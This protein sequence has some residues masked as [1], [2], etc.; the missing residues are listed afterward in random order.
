MASTSS[1]PPSQNSGLM[2][3][4]SA[5][6][7][8][9]AF[10]V[11]ALGI[12]IALLMEDVPV[13]LIGVCIS[14]LGSIAVFVLYAQRVKDSSALQQMSKPVKTVSDVS[15]FK[16]T[17]KQETGSKRLVFDDFAE[18]F[19]T[20]DVQ[21]APQASISQPF[22]ENLPKN[23]SSQ[24]EPSSSSKKQTEKQ[25]TEAP[26]PAKAQSQQPTLPK[27]LVFDDF[28]DMAGF[29][30]V[31][32]VKLITAPQKF[33]PQTLPPVLPSFSAASGESSPSSSQPSSSQPS[34]SLP[35]SGKKVLVFDDAN[36][37]ASLNNDF[38][39][40]IAI[41]STV[42]PAS[43]QK[44]QPPEA[45]SPAPSVFTRT[46]AIAG[47]YIAPK[48]DE[49]LLGAGFDDDDG[50]EFRI[51]GKTPAVATTSAP[52]PSATTP[53]AEELSKKK[54]VDPTPEQPVQTLTASA[55]A[56]T[57]TPIEIP[58]D[59]VP[60][61]LSTPNIPS[62]GE[63]LTEVE[64]VQDKVTRASK[65]ALHVA[66][67][68]LEPREIASVA[69]QAS[70][71]RS[72]DAMAAAQAADVQ[73]YSPAKL[74]LKLNTS[75]IALG[76]V[77]TEIPEETVS[78]RRKKL[79]VTMDEIAE[80]AP[81]VVKNEPRKEFDFL[82]QRVLM[83]IRSAMNARTTVYWW[84]AA[85]RK[86]LTMEAKISDVSDTIQS[87]TIAALGDD[88]VSQIAQSGTPEILSEISTDAELRLLPYYTSPAKTRS[89]VGVPV[90]YNNAVVGVLTADSTEDDAYDNATVSFLG[91]FTK[92]ISGLI[93]SYTEKYDLL[94]SARTLDAI[95][96]FRQLTL[97][98]ERTG[99]DICTALIRS[100]M[101]LV[102]YNTMGTCIFSD[103]RAN[104]YVSNMHTKT[105]EAREILGADV[106]LETSLLGKTISNG[107]TYRFANPA[108]TFVRVTEQ[109]LK[110]D[111]LAF[112]A[113]P[114][115]SVSRCYGAL[116]IEETGETRLSKQD[117]EILETACEYAGTALE[118]IQLQD[119]VQSH[120][121]VKDVS[122]ERVI[123]S[124]DFI[125]RA[126]QEMARAADVKLSFT[127]AL[128]CL[129]EYAAFSSNDTLR[130]ELFRMFLET[131]KKN[132]R[133]YDVVGQF[134]RNA[135]AVCLVEKNTQEAQMWAERLR[136]EIASVPQN[137]KGKQFTITASIGVA[138]FLKQT[139][140][141]ELLTHAE[142]ALDV[143][144]R[145]TNS[146]SVFS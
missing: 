123:S 145:K 60:K 95:D 100:L 112:T 121:L 5:A 62:T 98:P 34:S 113:V 107:R 16:T 2:R 131:V 96:T 126:R 59:P 89:F 108:Q 129:D 45:V 80:E 133:E 54:D 127:V 83:A 4:F 105:P 104:W 72:S 47:N 120:T 51:L 52:S 55:V 103:D 33:T 44:P 43:L 85:D 24:A 20:V 23:T 124:S 76:Q 53:S 144:V 38:Q 101:R 63:R 25:G 56:P 18:S 118:Q 7:D 91:H 134:G 142:K 39:A 69:S 28:D 15:D 141:E 14:I 130:E 58:A 19:A 67:V 75:N 57:L 132:A 136:R 109:E 1:T 97:K 111:T 122:D 77:S 27:K 8:V 143:A 46:E 9:P 26:S 35:S 81:E 10:I 137:V 99:E 88:A 12:A 128:L 3:L 115:V 37:S 42:L 106:F 40:N 61:P 90:F 66:T 41:G 102:P 138:E 50:G 86:Q 36:E 94:Q 13:R 73:S 30:D 92:L 135:V 114:L 48:L 78:H 82:L 22:E 93:Q 139:S 21:A 116:F 140:L 68:E 32:E 84:Y 31:N 11:I 119:Y 49:S 146:V 17:V 70:E 6:T 74:D 87:R 125:E 29:D 65:A 71:M 79:T 117:I 64:D 110:P